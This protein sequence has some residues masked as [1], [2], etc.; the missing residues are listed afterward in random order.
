MHP[1]TFITMKH[2]L[3]L[4]AATLLVPFFSFAQSNYKPGYVVTLKGD[5]VK[6]FIDYR[7]WD[8]NPETID[9]KSSLTDK[10]RAKYGVE[11]LN[12][13]SVTGLESYV[14]YS[15]S[16]STNPT[17]P[18]QIQNYRDTS[19]RVGTVFLKVLEKG[20]RIA[21]YSYK[22]EL[23]TRFFIGDNPSYT[24]KE[25]IYRTYTD[26]SYDRNLGIAKDGTTT[27]KTYQK[28]ISAL[29]LKYNELN[30]NLIVY[31]SKADY[32][33]DDLLQIISKINHMTKAEYNKKHYSGSSLN[34]FAGLAA[35]I[36]TNSPNTSS[37]YY[38]A[39][40]RSYTSILPAPFFGMNLF[41]NP[42]TKKLQI[43]LEFSIAPGSYKS[44]FTDKVYPYLPT[45]VS[46]NEL[47]LTASPQVVYNFYNADNFKVFAG[48]GLE[49]SKFSFSNGYF[50]TQNH[51][52]S[53]SDLATTNPFFF[54]NWDDSFVFKAGIQFTKNFQIFANYQ[55]STLTTRDSYFAMT[56][57]CAQV[58]VL[59]LFNF[60]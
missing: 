37:P 8:L 47:A 27:E 22:D 26:P 24:P 32:I 25:L 52:G 9:F 14:R 6:G 57:T 2:F 33:A 55:S 35:N 31:I 58:G 19:F 42:A 39:G 1:Q 49:F 38:A 60:K 36:N 11:E 34:L 4:L 54:S 30:E 23:K 10:S 17:D 44:M 5:T 13:F 7:E 56:S 20:D 51:D 59:Y 53:E 41:A 48:I 45:E 3:P 16:I 21:L 15:G 40:G 50:G 46:F 29:A 12:S 18:Y 28:Q 43:R